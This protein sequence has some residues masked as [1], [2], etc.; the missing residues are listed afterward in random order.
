MIFLKKIIL[1]LF[2][3]PL[4]VYSQSGRSKKTYVYVSKVPK[5]KYPSDLIVYN[6]KFIDN[7]QS[8]NN[9]LDAKEK[10]K[11]QFTVK[12]NGKGDAY[13]LRLDAKQKSTLKGLSFEKEVELGNMKSGDSSTFTFPIEA[14]ADIKTDLVELNILIKEANGFDSDPVIIKFK[15]QEFRAPKLEVIDGQFV[16]TENIE[17]KAGGSGAIEVLI[18]NI[19]QGEAHDVTVEFVLPAN[20][21]YPTGDRIFN[22]SSINANQAINLKCGFIL[23]KRFD[24]QTL[25]IDVILTEK[26]KTKLERRA[27]SFE[28]GESM[29]NAIVYDIDGQLDNDVS[30]ENKSLNA[31]V[32]KNIPELGEVHSNKIALIIG[33][34]H[35]S[36]FQSS[37]QTEVDVAYAIN[38]AFVFRSYCLKTLGVPVENIVYLT[39]AT[40]AQMK[41]AIFKVKE[42]VKAIN[43]TG[44]QCEVIAFYAGHGL[45]NDNKEAYLIPVDVEGVNVESGIKLSFLYKQL[46]FYKS[47]RVSVFLDACFTGGA[48][49]QGLVAARGVKVSPKDD[50]LSGNLIVFAASQGNEASMPW[51][52]KGHG[53]FTYF[54]LKKIQESKGSLSY[55]ELNAYLT[56]KVPLNSLLIN[57]TK[58]TPKLMT[59]P[60]LGEDWRKWKL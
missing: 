48:R 41:Q 17:L 25:I 12:N 59:S 43:N 7:I 22:F 23:N 33:N 10:A 24:K 4:S 56:E 14:N 16:S 44:L 32:D 60:S 46:T 11:I 8:K 51:K 27:F 1:I 34:E 5:P 50:F 28:I 47:K 13:L 6:V 9:I 2:L 20:N 49:G 52:S 29:T 54:L 37:L 30:I 58:Q 19:G 15:S 40:S 26:D 18:Q 42:L 35:Y 31:D 39:D 45:P 55:Q 38:D 3:L 21:V 53:M 36:K 57:S